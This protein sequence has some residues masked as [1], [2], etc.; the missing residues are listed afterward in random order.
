MHDVAI[1]ASSSSM[2]KGVE[3]DVVEL[4]SE[5]SPLLSVVVGVEIEE[6]LPELAMLSES[7]VFLG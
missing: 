3:D 1:L 4:A 7:C 6:A 5:A 2:L